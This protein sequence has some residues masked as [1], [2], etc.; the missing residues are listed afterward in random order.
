MKKIV[1][2]WSILIFIFLQFCL[3]STQANANGNYSFRVLNESLKVTMN[4]DGSAGYYYEIEFYCMEYADP[5]DI[6]DIYMPVHFGCV[7]KS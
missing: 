3:F 1:I 5:I 4:D 2:T 7:I 6:V